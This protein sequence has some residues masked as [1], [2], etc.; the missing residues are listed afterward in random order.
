MHIASF[1]QSESRCATETVLALLRNPDY[2][3]YGEGVTSR[4]RGLD[5]GE[6]AFNRMSMEERSKV[7]EETLVNVGGRSRRSDYK[8]MCVALLPFPL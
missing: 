4:Q 3:V 8:N 7:K 1:C 5:N 2:A 6:S